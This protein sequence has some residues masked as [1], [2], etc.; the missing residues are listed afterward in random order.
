MDKISTTE[1]ETQEIGREFARNIKGGEVF[2][3]LGDLGSGKTT[4][5]KG[6]ANGLGIQKQITSPTFNIL[7]TYPVAGHPT[8]KCLIHIDAYRLESSQDAQSIGLSELLT[9][10][11]NVILVEWPENIWEAIKTRAKKIKFRFIDEKTRGIKY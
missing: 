11:N 3:L 2:A 4:F 9:D 6:F 7:K 10:K 1:K 8:V 5:A